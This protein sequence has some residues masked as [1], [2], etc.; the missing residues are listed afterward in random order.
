MRIIVTG[1][2][3][4][5]GASLC[6]RL[7]ADGHEL[8]VLTRRPRVSNQQPA[9]RH[10]LWDA[11]EWAREM[12]QADGVINLAGEPL[13]AKR[14]TPE[15]KRMIQ[16]SRVLSTRR[17]VQT[18]A[19]NLQRPRVL[20]NASAIGYYGPHDDEELTETA[21]AG[22]GFLADLCQRW[23]HEAQQAAPL[24][25]RVVQLR[26]GIVLS[27]DGGALSKMAPPFRWFLGGPLGSGRQWMS[28]IHRDDVLGLIAWALSHSDIAGPVNATAPQAVRMREFCQGL[29]RALRRPSWAPVPGPVL[30]ALL[31]EMADVLLT[32]QRVIPQAAL[33]A[34]Y[35]F[36]YPELGGALTACLSALP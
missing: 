15:Q 1:G 33:R 4:F 6:R 24:G 5:I 13:V 2:T 16:D 8:L 25:V 27:A 9:I 22:Q 17:L 20:I 32:G 23:E 3:G 11:P 18:M 21:P 30:R 36:Q 19:A 14:W 28:W 26:I 12:A 29:G 7:T 10:L 34:G 31:G 35:A